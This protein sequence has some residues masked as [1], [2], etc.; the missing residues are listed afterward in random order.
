MQH[1]TES[2]ENLLDIICCNKKWSVLCCIC[3]FLLTVGKWYSFR[4]ISVIEQPLQ[5]L[6]TNRS[7]PTR[8]THIPAGLAYHNHFIFTYRKSA[9]NALFGKSRQIF[10]YVFCF[11]DPTKHASH[12]NQFKRNLI[13]ICV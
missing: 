1:E 13:E 7:L 10:G 2:G 11:E 6:P 3:R 9:K 4:V 5:L 12:Q 8:L